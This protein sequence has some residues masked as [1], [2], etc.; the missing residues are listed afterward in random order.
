LASQ[1]NA[2]V[3]IFVIISSVSSM[4]TPD[5]ED[6]HIPPLLSQR[7]QNIAD[8]LVKRGDYKYVMI[9]LWHDAVN[10]LPDVT[11]ASGSSLNLSRGLRAGSL[12]VS[13]HLLE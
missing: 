8:A 13:I 5:P 12:S 10:H 7:A 1:T 2:Y 6:I 3:E 11:A 4:S 9:D